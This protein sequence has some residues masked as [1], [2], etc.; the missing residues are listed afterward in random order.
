LADQDATTGCT[1]TDSKPVLKEKNKIMAGVNSGARSQT[2]ILVTDFL[3]RCLSSFITENRRY[4]TV[5][6]YTQLWEKIIEAALH[7]KDVAGP[8]LPGQRVPG[9][10]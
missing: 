9:A 7:G 4:S 6:G 3:D 5:S 10:G 8:D 1:S 2:E